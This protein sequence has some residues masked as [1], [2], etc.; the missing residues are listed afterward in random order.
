MIAKGIPAD[1]VLHAWAINWPESARE[2]C[3]I[4]PWDPAEFR[5]D[6]VPKDRHKL[7]PY[8]RTLIEAGVPVYLKGPSQAGKSFVLAQ[9]ARDLSMPFR[10]IPLTAGASTSWLLGTWTPQGWVEAGFPAIYTGGG[11]FLFD[12]IDAGD[13]NMLIV[14]NNA[15]SNDTLDN[16]RNGEVLR[17]SPLFRP[18]AAGNTWGTGATSQYTGRARMDG[19][20]LERFRCGRVEV[21]YDPDM[22]EQIGDAAFAAAMNGE[23]A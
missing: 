20:T 13:P 2:A 11:V 4:E 10:Q 7:Y 14:V 8:I 21:D 6:D 15:V 12:E 1:G 18:V 9:V 3:G 16:P 5:R 19:A 23:V 22:Q 17:K